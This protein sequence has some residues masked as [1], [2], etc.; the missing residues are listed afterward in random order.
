[1]LKTRKIIHPRSPL[2]P[3]PFWPFR[4]WL[5]PRKKNEFDFDAKLMILERI[6]TKI[7]QNIVFV[8]R[9]CVQPPGPLRYRH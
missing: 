4:E 2:A 7:D 9:F 6:L 1:M 5:Q 8:R 3:P